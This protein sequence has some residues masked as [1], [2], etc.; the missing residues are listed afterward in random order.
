MQESSLVSVANVKIFTLKFIHS[1]LF[2]YLTF[3]AI[4]IFYCGIIQQTSDLL[5]FS[6][7]TMVL[8]GI[9]IAI[10]N[11]KCPLAVYAE[12]MGSE[13]GRVTQYFL[14]KGF[15]PH[16]FKTYFAVIMMGLLLLLLGNIT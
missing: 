2:F 6:I 11:F 3:T 4:Y 12:N 7:I 16:V 1:I 8:E 5:L 14:P 13:D 15:V 9:A 10:Y